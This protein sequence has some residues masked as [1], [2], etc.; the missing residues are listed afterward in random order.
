[1]IKGQAAVIA[2]E[3]TIAWATN[4][5]LSEQN[6]QSRVTIAFPRL[7][8]RG[9]SGWQPPSPTLAGAVAGL[10]NPHSRPPYTPPPKY[11]GPEHGIPSVIVYLNGILDVEYYVS[12]H[13]MMRLL[14]VGCMVIQ[15]D[16]KGQGYVRIPLNSPPITGQ[17][18]QFE[19]A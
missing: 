13:Y 19:V 18:Y 10:I 11:Y 14:N 5:R 6:L 2:A 8:I 15:K 9:L 17:P 12:K 4:Q 7:K 1:M 3:L 16:R